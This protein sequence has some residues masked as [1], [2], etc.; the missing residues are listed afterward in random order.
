MYLFFTLMKKS[1]QIDQGG[2]EE[3]YIYNMKNTKQ[4]EQHKI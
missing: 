2:S 4:S 3:L 1:T